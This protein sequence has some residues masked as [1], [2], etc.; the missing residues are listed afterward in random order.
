MQHGRRAD[1]SGQTRSIG[2]GFGAR[3]G[4][5]FGAR[6]G[7]GFGARL[8]CGFGAR[9]GCGFGARLGCGGLRLGSGAGRYPDG[10]RR[11]KQSF[12]CAL[13]PRRHRRALGEPE[14]RAHTEHDHR[15]HE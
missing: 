4:C 11:R 12:G 5:G 1:V 13:D 8:D 9:L 7:C 6:L 2:C 3:L 14:A 10:C 15:S